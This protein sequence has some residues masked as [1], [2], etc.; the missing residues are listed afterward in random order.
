MNLQRRSKSFQCSHGA[1]GLGLADVCDVPVVPVY[2]YIPLVGDRAGHVSDIVQSP[3]G[4]EVRVKEPLRQV[5]RVL[6]EG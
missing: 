2:K 4:K 6:R 3:G 5:K 1:E